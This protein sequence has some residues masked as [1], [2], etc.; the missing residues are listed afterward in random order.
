VLGYAKVIQKKLSD[1]IL[2][3]VDTADPK[4]ERAVRQVSENL[5]SRR[6]GSRDCR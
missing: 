6:R 4:T 1:Q 5:R 2:P 3:K